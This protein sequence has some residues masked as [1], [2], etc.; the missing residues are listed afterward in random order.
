MKLLQKAKNETAFLKA[1]IQGLAGTGKTYSASKIAIGLGKYIESNKPIAFLDTET[2]SDFVLPTFQQ[3]GFDLLTCKSRAFVDLIETMHEAEKSCDILIID[4]ITHFWNELVSTYQRKNNRSRLTLKD[5]MPIKQE[6]RQ[7]TDLYLI[8]KLHII[9]CG[10]AGWDWDFQE[11]E[12]GAKELVKTGTK[13]KVES[14]TGFEPSLLIEMERVRKDKDKVGSGW[15]HRAWILK[16]RSDKINGL[17]FDNV[18]FEHVLPHIESLNLKGNHKVLDLTRTSDGLFHSEKSLSDMYKKRDIAL[19]EIKDE[20]ILRY[21]G[22]SAEDQSKKIT[23]LK[24][25]FGTSSW[26]SIS[27]MSL[28]QV[29]SGLEGIKKIAIPIKNGEVQVQTKKEKKVKGG[30]N[31]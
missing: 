28:E 24:Q 7:Y 14:E 26:T 22:R 13:M 6:W 21:P 20:I 3:A 4:S 9:M 11:D 1:G 27:N 31:G 19:E 8:S 16:D 2:G 25:I 29:Q 15:I 18:T 5:W 17:F 30:Q 12:D 23:L 10:R